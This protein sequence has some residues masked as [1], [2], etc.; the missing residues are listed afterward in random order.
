MLTTLL[1]KKKSLTKDVD[2]G[3][4]ELENMKEEVVAICRKDVDKFKG[5]S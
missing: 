3:T 4:D 5:N 2:K 1:S